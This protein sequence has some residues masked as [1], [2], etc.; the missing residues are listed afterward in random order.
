MI[1]TQEEAKTK[2]CP[3]TKVSKCLGVECMW[4]VFTSH[5]G[6]KEPLGTCG[7]VAYTSTSIAAMLLK[8]LVKI[9]NENH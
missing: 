4:F 9:T 8:L 5:L 2:W 6:A 7:I 3:K 1:V